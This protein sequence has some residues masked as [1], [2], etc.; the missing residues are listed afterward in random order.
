MSIYVDDDLDPNRPGM[1]H[2]HSLSPEE[3]RRLAI[4]LLRRNGASIIEKIDIN[5]G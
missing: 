2:L 3:E 5:H 1:K 4:F